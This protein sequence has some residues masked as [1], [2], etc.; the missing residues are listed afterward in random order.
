MIIYKIFHLIVSFFLRTTKRGSYPRSGIDTQCG[1]MS[2]QA[3]TGARWP[4]ISHSIPLLLSALSIL[5]RWILRL[6]PRKEKL[7][8]KIAR[9]SVT[10]IMI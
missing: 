10:I 6:A 1:E 9:I 4:L 5:R 3:Q 8:M 7:E 2:H